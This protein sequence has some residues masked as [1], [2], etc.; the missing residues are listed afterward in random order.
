MSVKGITV[1]LCKTDFNNDALELGVW[2]S[3][4][5]GLSKNV[6]QVEVRVVGRSD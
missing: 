5:E 3:L 4:T 6:K 2:N 1:E